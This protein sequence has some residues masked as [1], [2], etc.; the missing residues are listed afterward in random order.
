MMIRHVEWCPLLWL[1]SRDPAM[2]L[3]LIWRSGTLDKISGA[4]A[5][6]LE[7]YRGCSGNGYQ[8]DMHHLQN[9]WLNE[10]R[11]SWGVKLFIRCQGVSNR[12]SETN[13]HYMNWNC[14]LI[15]KPCPHDRVYCAKSKFFAAR[16]GCF[17]KLWEK[18]YHGTSYEMGV[19]SRD[20]FWSQKKPSNGS[21][22]MCIKG[23]MS[24][25]VCVTFTWDMYIYE[26]F[27]AFVSFVVCS[28]L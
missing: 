14:L 1:L 3:Q 26:L 11:F 6:W 8:G 22:C 2:S 23:E 4:A 13:G 20:I 10:E 18:G 5:T 25:T 21:W 16:L 12:Y 15:L 7:D 24:G 27:I 28:L 19:R 9:Y 17:C